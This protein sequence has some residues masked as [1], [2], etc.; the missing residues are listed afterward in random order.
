MSNAFLL[1]PDYIPKWLPC[2]KR[3]NDNYTVGQDM[4]CCCTECPE[5]S[6]AEIDICYETYRENLIV[7]MRNAGY[8]VSKENWIE[9]KDKYLEKKMKQQQEEE[10]ECDP[11]CYLSQIPI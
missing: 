8:K 3:V 10:M 9:F 6:Y 2:G 1:L 11:Q 7:E 5:K 4:Q